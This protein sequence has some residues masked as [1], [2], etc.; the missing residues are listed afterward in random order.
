M[1]QL[2]K[3]TLQAHQQQLSCNLSHIFAC[4]DSHASVWSQGS[5]LKL[6]PRQHMVGAATAAIRNIVS[7]AYLPFQRL[8]MAACVPYILI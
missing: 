6:Q 4:I 5:C 1:L 8:C 7:E 2:Y 3:Y